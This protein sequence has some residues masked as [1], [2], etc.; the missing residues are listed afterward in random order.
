MYGVGLLSAAA[1]VVLARLK[2]EKLE[3]EGIN[4]R[5]WSVLLTLCSI[6]LTAWGGGAR[7]RIGGRGGG[8]CAKN[9]D[10]YMGPSST[11]IQSHVLRMRLLRPAPVAKATV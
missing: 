2:F 9:S 5:F 11:S 1:A 10:W 6:P 8:G 4:S 3:R 7:G